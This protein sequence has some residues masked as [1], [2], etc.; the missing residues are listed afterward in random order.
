MILSRTKNIESGWTPMF[1]VFS[2]AAQDVAASLA[3]PGFKLA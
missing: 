1:S 2:L 3:Q